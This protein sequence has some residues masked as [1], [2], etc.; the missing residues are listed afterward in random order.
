MVV[1]APIIEGLANQWVEGSMY[2]LKALM[3][4]VRRFQR[5]LGHLA[6]SQGSGGPWRN[7][8]LVGALETLVETFGLNATT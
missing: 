3:Y 4:V 2:E 1:A 7:S 6:S 8:F 5:N